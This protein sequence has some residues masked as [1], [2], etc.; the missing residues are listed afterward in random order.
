M[1][2]GHPNRALSSGFF[3]DPLARMRR[4][5]LLSLGATSLTAAL[6]GCV[7]P[8]HP[9]DPTAAEP[10][11][12]SPTGRATGGDYGWFEDNDELT[13][14]FG[15]TWVAGLTPGQVIQ[16]IGG[17]RLGTS[18]W[19]PE[20]VVTPGRRP[21]EAVMAV[22][23]T[24]GWSL[25]VEDI[26]T[27]TSRDDLLQRLSVR[28]TVVTHSRNV[29]LDSRFTLIKNG[30]VQVAFDPYDPS[31]RTG[32]HPDML[33]TAMRAAGF[34]A[35]DQDTD[36]ADATEW[37]FALTE[38]LTGVPMTITLLHSATYVITA[39]YDADT[40]AWEQENPYR[41]LQSE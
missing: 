6:A 32:S 10:S 1:R 13:D 20:L 26:G 37:A 23:A 18:G 2:D 35:D 15:F 8:A 28:T 39:V 30:D 11:A 41:G 29:E 3:H 40:A 4:R 31:D 25:I 34:P 22:A 36:G 19:Q 7:Q 12:L 9:T 5:T 33:L 27:L 21:G 14:G 16:R 24:P 17:R 38:R